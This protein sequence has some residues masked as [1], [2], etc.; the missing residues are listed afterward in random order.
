MKRF[1]HKT[2]LNFIFLIPLL[3]SCDINLTIEDVL[4]DYLDSSTLVYT[5][6]ININGYEIDSSIIT[7]NKNKSVSAYYYI[8]TNEYYSEI[9]DGNSDTL[10]EEGYTNFLK[11]LDIEED[12][13]LLI[14]IESTLRYRI[15]LNENTN[16]Y[17]TQLLYMV[18]GNFSNVIDSLTIN[19][20]LLIYTYTEVETVEIY[21]TFEDD[22]DVDIILTT[23]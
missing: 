7:I 6:I 12:L 21:L 1:K 23:T 15:Y 22:Q 20:A 19:Y 9:L 8:G 13:N 11:D 5:S 16:N 17:L 10:L 2:F 18:T 3:L 14:E 4:L